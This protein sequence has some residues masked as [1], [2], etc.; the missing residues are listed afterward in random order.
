MSPDT[1]RF[2][3]SD[4]YSLRRRLGS[5]SFGEVYEVYDRKRSSRIALK[6]LKD[7]STLLQ[8][9]DEF[10]GL[11]DIQHPNLVQL[12]E[13]ASDGGQWF[14]TMELVDGVSFR[15]YVTGADASQTSTSNDLATADLA[16][17]D[18]ATASMLHGIGIESTVATPPGLMRRGG[19]C[20]EKRLRAALLQLAEGVAALHG[21]GKLHRDLKPSNV[22]VTAGGR[23][24]LLDFGLVAE[25][26]DGSFPRTLHVVGTPAYMSP[27]QGAGTAITEASDWYA[28]GVMLF[29]ALTG[30]LPFQG[31]MAEVL[32]WKRHTEAP[33]PATIAPCIPRDLNS[34]CCDLLRMEP[35]DRPPGADILERL[36]A[37]QPPERLIAASSARDRRLP[38]L[39]REEHMAALHDAYLRSQAGKAVIVL[40]HGDSGMGKTTLVRHFFDDLRRRN[41]HA[42]LLRGRCYEQESVPY[43]GFDSLMD[44]VCRHLQKVLGVELERILPR[45]IVALAK[46]F[47]V[48][49]QVPGVSDGRRRAF[50]IQDSQE[51]RRRAFAAQRELVARLA[52]Q[53]PVV[54][55]IDD[56]QWGDADSA[57]LLTEIMRPPDPP[58][59]LFIASFRS[60]QRQTPVIRSIFNLRDTAAAVLDIRELA[61]AE[62]SPASAR[63]LVLRLAERGVALSPERADAIVRESGGS[64]IFID[65]LVR[66]LGDDQPAQLSLDTAIYRRVSALPDGARRMLGVLAVARRPVSW[67]ACGDAAGILP[68]A[69]AA[70]LD[71]LR[72]QRLVRVHKAEQREQYEVY[73]ARI[74]DTIIGHVAESDLKDCHRRVALALESAGEADAETLY[75]HY[76][77][78]GQLEVAAR[79]AVTAAA[80]AA[81]ALAFDRAARL[82][83]AALELRGRDGIAALPLWVEL[84]NA[85]RNAGRG[86]QAARAYL[87][88]AAGSTPHQRIDLERRAAESLLGSGHIDRGLVVVKSVLRELGLRMPR[89]PRTALLGLVLRRLQARLRGLRYRE[90][91][92][93]TLDPRDL[94][95]LDTCWSLSVGLGM[96]DTIR[97]AYFQVRYLL[98]ALKAGEPARV[99]RALA[100]EVGFS[101]NAGG[102]AS[103]RTARI[104]SQTMALANRVGDP[105]AIG[106]AHVSRGVAFYLEGNWKGSL[107]HCGR[108]EE[109]IRERCAGMSQELDTAH[110]FLLRSLYFLGEIKE[111]ARR[112]PELLKDAEDRGDLYGK[113]MLSIRNLYIVHLAADRTAQARQE[114]REAIERW[115]QQGFHNQHYVYLCAQTEM[116]L[117]LGEGALAWSRI[118]EG[119]E[120]LKKSMLLRVQFALLEATHLRARCALA[121]AAGGD[122][123]LLRQ[124]ETAVAIIEKEN[125]P[126]ANAL[127]L[128]IRA[129]IAAASDRRD[130]AIAL[131]AESETQLTAAGM[132][133]FA[134]AASRRRGEA[135]GG[136]PGRQ[137]VA[138]ADRQ[139]AA[140]Q[141]V[142]PSRVTAMLLPGRFDSL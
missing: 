75:V 132:R 123:G 62:L 56:L 117:Y 65:E 88:A 23:V 90:R 131:L 111:L 128:T 46:V 51:L 118:T 32:H 113:T 25:M 16:T 68:E 66:T 127:A 133:L 115:S 78:A 96:V 43:K 86:D 39:G 138:A 87:T 102:R 95:R 63:E 10:R 104:A 84:G 48:L 99:A 135:L 116:D 89:S 98:L 24:V 4:R 79:Y 121:A 136:E 8:F 29:E 53:R 129:G 31:G 71:V 34:L 6:V 101:A 55:F 93:A 126:W 7:T 5:G 139:M 77:A 17:P 81:A 41:P 57:G 12:H 108:A 30:Q 122:S 54:M 100:L 42:L 21:A 76:R 58:G 64:P 82:Y 109:I 107:D 119:W 15:D 59:V 50:E 112:L 73:H 105:Q 125:M 13:L 124:A 52:D 94:L 47:P 72:R 130:E 1:F 91:S 120:A 22:L 33:A 92:A 49:M 134:T 74:A 26:D 27:E 85:L 9:K 61:V 20:D 114:S 19:I 11:A 141:I 38:F 70:A 106:M 28:V 142:N 14:F 69:R 67:D 45:D 44:A 103:D 37:G 18:L 83:N 110:H 80:Q 36:R 2:A 60:D 140:Q 137:L 40:L 97:A 35:G 3:G